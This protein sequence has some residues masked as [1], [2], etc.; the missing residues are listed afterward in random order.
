MAEEAGADQVYSNGDD[1]APQVGIVSQYV[2]DLS[3]E[4]PNA[5]A[6]YQWQGQPAMDVEF[7]IG[8]QKLSDEINEVVL[9]I[10]ITARSDDKIAFQLELLYAGL[11]AMRNVPEEQVQPFLLAEAPRILFPFA[12]QT[13]AH[14]VQDG[15]FPPLLLDPIDFG[16]L[17]MQRA[18]QQQAE[19]GGTTAGEITGQA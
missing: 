5:P 13:V 17:Y 3:F 9:K 2:K 12:R 10:N 7:N 16:A 14:A 8:A 18:A 1:T 6:V 4:N 15:G 19:A 11:I